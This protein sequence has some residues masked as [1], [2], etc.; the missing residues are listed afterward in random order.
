VQSLSQ[1]PNI[2]QGR[3][4]YE[5]SP[6]V[7]AAFE[8]SAMVIDEADKAPTHVT[9]VLKTL[10]E[11]GEMLLADGRRLVPHDFSVEAL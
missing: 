1:Q 6:L 3:L 4:T 10:V 11:D 2:A 9:C 5:D 7:R 8:G